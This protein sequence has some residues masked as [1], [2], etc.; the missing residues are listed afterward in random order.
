MSGGDDAALNKVPICSGLVSSQC[1]SWRE[2]ALRYGDKGHR[3]RDT[4]QAVEWPTKKKEYQILSRDL[5]VP[6]RP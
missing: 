5:S 3:D 2:P 1:G 6:R 4:V